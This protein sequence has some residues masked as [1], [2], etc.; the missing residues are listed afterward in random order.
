M[1][2]IQGLVA[3][4]MVSAKDVSSNSGKEWHTLVKMKLSSNKNSC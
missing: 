3:R 4:S 2:K 1:V